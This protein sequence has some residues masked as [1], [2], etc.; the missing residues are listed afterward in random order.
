M[1]YLILKTIH[2]LSSTL[3]FGAGTGTAILIFRA[4]LMRNDERNEALQFAL[5]HAISVDWYFTLAAGIVQLI[6]GITMGIMA[7]YSFTGGWLFASLLL[8]IAVFSL[9][10][11]AA[12][13]QMRMKK[14][15][16]HSSGEI[17][18]AFHRMIKIWIM[19]GIPAFI[20]MIFI[21]I[22]MIFRSQIFF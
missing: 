20:L 18:P 14:D 13:L 17:T 3:L 9:W 22:L 6:T 19:L 5:N 16:L 8:F 7:G 11:P 4:F 10:V 2:I 12:A 15:L 21:F 1:T